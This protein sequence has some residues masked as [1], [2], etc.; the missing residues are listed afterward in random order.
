MRRYSAEFL[1]T[2][3]LLFTICCT[4]MSPSQ[5]VRDLA[6]LAIGAVLVAMIFA[7]GHISGGHFNPAVTVAVW[8]RGRIAF[9]DVLPYLAAQVLG[10]LFGALL[11]RFV[12]NG[13]SQALTASGRHLVPTR[14]AWTL[15]DCHT[16]IFPKSAKD[17]K[18]DMNGQRTQTARRIG[19]AEKAVL[20]RIRTCFRT[21]SN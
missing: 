5:P 17:F 16:E 3:F 8:V 14:A 1:G 7:G 21:H 19:R 4:V 10:G 12:V 9:S 11:A 2:F 6:P 13:H 20:D 15:L 18:S